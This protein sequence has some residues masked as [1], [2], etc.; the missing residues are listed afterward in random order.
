MEYFGKA[1]YAKEQYQMAQVKEKLEIEILDIETE[2]IN[3]EEE[4]TID[5]LIN[6]LPGKLPGISIEKDGEGA[7]GTLDGYEFT[8]DKDFNVTIKGQDKSSSSNPET[9]PEQPVTPPTPT[10]YSVTFNGT[11]VTSNGASSTNENSTYTATLTAISGYSI[12]SVTV[13][14]GGTTLVENTGYTYSSGNLSIPNV[15]GDIQIT[16]IG[17]KIQITASNYGEYV[18]YGIDLNDNGIT[19]D[20]WMIFYREE[21]DINPEYKGATYIIPAYYVPYSKMTTSISNA[22]MTQ[23]SNSTYK[24]YWSSVP[25]YKTVTDIVKQVFMYDHTGTSGDHIKCVSR[26]LDASAWEGDF[27]TSKLKTKGGLAIGGPTLN[28]WCESWNK[29]YSAEK[30]TPSIS[31]NGYQVNGTDS[32]MLNTYEGYISAPNVYFP[33][34]GPNSETSYWISSSD[35]ANSSNVYMIDTNKGRIY[36]HT[37]CLSYSGIRPIVYLP[38]SVQLIPSGTEKVWNIYYGE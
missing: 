31:G 34:V 29:S 33:T 6:E 15:S 20:D 7:K 8:I 1:K 2:K 17:E 5:T 26:L 24:V 27:V 22:K 36:P 32:L 21:G 35:A 9:P 19:T 18:D 28:M 3:N 30:V 10:V 4:C 13:T 11:N 14:M 37:Y 38:S 23:Y 16:A 25:T 12:T